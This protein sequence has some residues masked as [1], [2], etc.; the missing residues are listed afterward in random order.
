MQPAAVFQHSA[1]AAAQVAPYGY[2]PLSPGKT[3]YLYWALVSS[4]ELYWALPR[5]CTVR[6]PRPLHH[7]NTSE[8]WPNVTDTVSP[9]HPHHS[10]IDSFMFNHFMFIIRFILNIIIMV[11]SN[12]HYYYT[13]YYII[14]II[15]RNYKI[16]FSRRPL[17]QQVQAP[18]VEHSSKIVPFVKNLKF[19]NSTCLEQNWSTC[20]YWTLL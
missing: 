8:H 17:L 3:R 2:A 10:L 13:W 18:P 5:K 4:T 1:A 19:S 7:H 16:S 15:I 14:L 9:S 11:H 6:R 20:K 12:S